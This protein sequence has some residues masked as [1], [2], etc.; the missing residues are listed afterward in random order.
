M[1]RL[2]PALLLAL[3]GCT[4]GTVTFDEVK[5]ADSDCPVIA[6]DRDAIA[7]TGAQL[8]K[9]SEEA[10]TL[11]NACLGAGDLHVETSVDG[12]PSFA[13]AGGAFDIVPGGNDAFIVLFTAPDNGSHT[14]YL[15]L[16]SNDPTRPTVQIP[17][18]GTAGQDADGDGYLAEYAGGEDCDD[19]D[20]AVNPGVTET[21]YDGIDANCDGAD[22]YDQ[23]GDGIRATNFGGDDCDDTNPDVSGVSPEKLD[24]TD[25]DCDGLVDEDFL[26]SGDVLVSEVMHHPLMVS[27]VDG[28]WFELRNT[29]ERDIDMIGWDVRSD[30]GDAFHIGDTLVVPSGGSLVFGANDDS[31]ANGGATVHYPYDRTHFSLSAADTLILAAGTVT[32]F[33]IEW[34]EAWPVA[35]GASLGLDPDHGIM[36][37]ARLTSSWCLSKTLLVSGDKGTPGSMNDQCTNIDEDGDGYSVDEHDCDDA[38]TTVSPGEDEV[39]DGLDNDCDGALDDAAVDDAAVGTV[40]GST[41]SWLTAARGLGVGDVVG[42]ATPDFVI[43]GSYASAYA[44]VAYVFDG[45]EAASVSGEASKSDTA[46]ITGESYGYF[47]VVSPTLGDNTG[48]GQTDLIIAG[49]DLYGTYYDT[50]SVALFSGGAGL[51]GALDKDDADLTLDSDLA[52]GGY[53]DSSVLTSADLDGDGT[54]EIVY[55]VPWGGPNGRYYS[56]V[57]YI[58]DPDGLTGALD[59]A[60]ADG[61]YYGDSSNDHLGYGLGGEDVD[62]DGYDDVYMGASAAD[63]SVTD[64]GAW[65][66]VAGGATHSSGGDIDDEAASVILGNDANGEIGFGTAVIVDFDG[67]GQEDLALGGYTVDAV[68][69]FFDADSLASDLETSDADIRI[70]GD[71]GGSFGFAISGGDVTGDGLADL[72]VGDPAVNSYYADPSYWWYQPGSTTGMLYLFDGADLS[73]GGDASDVAA[74]TMQ[75]EDPGDLF[76][77]TLSGVADMTGG[78]GGDFLVGAPRQ[79]GQA[80]RAYVIA[81]G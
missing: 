77:A 21:W 81:G 76:G 8:G 72:I 25:N 48:D 43:G 10:L 28:E 60:D 75:G 22:D 29:T 30:D 20:P 36:P 2:T 58:V 17:L 52:A 9:P 79:S 42:D 40:D 64:G 27:D 53:G 54:D 6:T 51:S 46:T 65:Y 63:D 31:A 66:L 26:V 55:G 78:T 41:S 68:F 1:R 35:D 19:G 69:I 34:N 33:D 3:A 47:G 4:T 38:D 59:V 39:W 5:G 32:V 67:D 12:D 57:I 73:S 13:A 16:T 18:A 50:V 49:A 61:T 45:D 11:S 24:N 14:G 70:D 74:A 44:G 80:G 37:D 23:D 71:A 56:G 7:F 62:H 15:V